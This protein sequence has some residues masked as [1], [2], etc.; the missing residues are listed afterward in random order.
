MFVMEQVK[1]HLAMV[2]HRFI[3]LGKVKIHLQD[4]EIEAW[5]PFLPNELATQGFPEEPLQNGKVIIKGFVLP[6]KSKISEEI[7]KK[8]EGPKGWNEQQG[9]YVYRNERLIL[10]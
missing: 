2:F 7:Y 4:R 9:F 3:E 6:H 8:S 1:K 5:N 10:A